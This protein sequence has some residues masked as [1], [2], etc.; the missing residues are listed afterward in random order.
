MTSLL[1]GSKRSYDFDEG[2]QIGTCDRSTIRESAASHE[3]DREI[4][5]FIMFYVPAPRTYLK[6]VLSKNRT[7]SVFD[8]QI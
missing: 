5:R 8:K 4:T 2:R 3:T 7:Q 1:A 6:V